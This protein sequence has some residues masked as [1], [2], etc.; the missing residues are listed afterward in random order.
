LIPNIFKM[1][2]KKKAVLQ[3]FTEQPSHLL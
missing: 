1:S 2:D 3:I